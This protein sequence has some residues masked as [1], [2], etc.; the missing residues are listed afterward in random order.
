[1]RRMINV[2]C[3]FKQSISPFYSIERALTFDFIFSLG[4]HFY[5][6]MSHNLI[7]CVNKIASDRMIIIKEIVFS[8]GRWIKI[9]QAIK[10]F[11]NYPHFFQN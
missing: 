6:F 2:R 11:H 4:E 1:M 10:T 5:K 3:I 8:D 9:L 7:Y